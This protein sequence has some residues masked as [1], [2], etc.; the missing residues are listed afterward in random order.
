MHTGRRGQVDAEI[1]V[2]LPEAKGYLDCHK[3]EEAR[4]F[5]KMPQ[6]PEFANT[7]I[8]TYGFQ[9]HERILVCY[10]KTPNL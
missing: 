3:V 5:P 10:F 9:N 7:L 6:T 2:M 1:S 4:I 8:W